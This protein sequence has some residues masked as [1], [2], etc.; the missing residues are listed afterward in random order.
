MRRDN[1]RSTS[2]ARLAMCAGWSAPRGGV[3]P[4][5]TFFF[6]G[7]LTPVEIQRLRGQ[8]AAAMRAEARIADGFVSLSEA[9]ALERRADVRTSPVAGTTPVARSLWRAC[10][11]ALQRGTQA[12]LRQIQG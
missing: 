3:R 11:S 2:R 12:L 6:D 10:T 1:L 9:R 5:Q 7:Q 4:G 8:F